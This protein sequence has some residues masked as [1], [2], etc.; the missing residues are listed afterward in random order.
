M[1]T[2]CLFMIAGAALQ[3]ASSIWMFI[4]GRVIS[5]AASGGATA[6]IPGFISE[7]SPPSLH[8]SLRIGFQ[9]AITVGNLLVA[10][11]FFFLGTSSGWRFIAGLPVV[12]AAL[13]LVLASFV[14]VE[15]PTARASLW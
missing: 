12:L 3:A 5:G 10:V 2:N 8:N 13:F 14:L 4:G 1:M 6:V 11:T 9:I 7:I 15:S